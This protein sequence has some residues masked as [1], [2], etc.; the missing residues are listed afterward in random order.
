M[1]TKKQT[2]EQID[3][4]KRQAAYRNAIETFTPQLNADCSNFEKAM[5]FAKVNGYEF[6]HDTSYN[7]FSN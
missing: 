4:T 3:L 2:P 7:G 1:E 5:Q 6:R